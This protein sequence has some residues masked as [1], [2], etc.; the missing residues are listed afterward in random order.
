MTHRIVE[1]NWLDARE[2]VTITELCDECGLSFADI[3]ELVEY[4]ALTPVEATQAERIFSA[5]C[6]APLRTAS[7]LRQAFE[8]DLFTVSLLLGYLHRIEGLEREVKSLR[9]Q[10]PGHGV[11]PHRGEGPE[12]WHE[13]HGLS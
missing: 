1:I 2:T 12:P 3:D 5:E 10:L 9:A 7:R 13:P 8:L 4:G 11:H 6:V